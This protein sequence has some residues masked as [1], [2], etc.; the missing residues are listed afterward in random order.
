MVQTQV[1]PPSS[2]ARQQ[3]SEFSLQDRYTVESG[4]IILSGIQALARLPIDQHR[5]DMRRGLHTGS[6]ITGYRGSPIGVLDMVLE[7]IPGSVG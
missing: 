6:L 1:S 5:A 7:Q 2:K 4:R 3:Q